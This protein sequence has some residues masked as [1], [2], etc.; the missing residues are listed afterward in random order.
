MFL[1][2]FQTTEIW[3]INLQLQMKKYC[4]KSMTVIIPQWKIVIDTKC[5][6]IEM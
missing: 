1:T 2:D 3:S 4:S 5:I 6:G